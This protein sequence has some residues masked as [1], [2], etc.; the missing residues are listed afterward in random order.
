MR[1]PSALAFAHPFLGCPSRGGAGLCCS[2]PR[3]THCRCRA[4][5]PG[6]KL[7]VLEMELLNAFVLYT[8]PYHF[9]TNRIMGTET[10]INM[11][12]DACQMQMKHEG[13]GSETANCAIINNCPAVTRPGP[14]R[15]CSAEGPWLVQ[16]PRTAEVAPGNF[17]LT[18][19]VTE[20][21]LCRSRQG[22]SLS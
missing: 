21:R 20:D 9:C 18:C 10:K 4:P 12:H 3:R 8:V 16:L 7:H 5:G 19:A 2:R 6:M 13:K 17:L 1:S 11:N 15:A 22:L 14:G